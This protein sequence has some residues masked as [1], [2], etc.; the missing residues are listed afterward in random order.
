MTEGNK[1]RKLLIEC[2]CV[3]CDRFRALASPGSYIEFRCSRC[4]RQN[5]IQVP[6]RAH[7]EP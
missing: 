2:R 4:K 3:K 5:K 7:V 1:D 6:D